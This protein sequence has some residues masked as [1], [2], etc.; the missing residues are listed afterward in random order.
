MCCWTGSRYCLW[1]TAFNF[2][3]FGQSSVANDRV[4]RALLPERPAPRGSGGAW[5]GGVGLGSFNPARGD[6][7]GETPGA[8]GFAGT[9]R[10]SVPAR[11]RRPSAGCPSACPG[12][13]TR[14]LWTPPHPRETARAPPAIATCRH[15]ARRHDA[16]GVATGESRGTGAFGPASNA[17]ASLPGGRCG[18]PLASPFGI[19]AVHRLFI[20]PAKRRA[21]VRSA[22][23]APRGVRRRVRRA[24]MQKIALSRP[25]LD[26]RRRVGGLPAAVSTRVTATHLSREMRGWAR[27]QPGARRR[28]C[29][30]PWP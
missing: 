26:A 9:A 12:A 30:P 8:S 29:R 11:W 27:V 15:D 2:E 25:V 20:S 17:Q 28:L 13:Q 16:P 24:T 14:R 5:N 23:V 21:N 10:L 18:A 6:G 19:H 3:C 7:E 22:R 4:A 1:W